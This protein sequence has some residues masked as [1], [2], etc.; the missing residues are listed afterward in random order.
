MNTL[1]K[2]NTEEAARNAF[3]YAIEKIHGP[4][5]EGE[6][7]ISKSAN[8]SYYYAEFL[9]TRFKMGEKAIKGTTGYL[10]LYESNVLKCPLADLEARDKLIEEAKQSVI[11]PISRL[12]IE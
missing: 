12:E 3:C 8:Y 7:S 1:E 10:Q 5:K 6:E 2:E 4:Y 9:K 11:N